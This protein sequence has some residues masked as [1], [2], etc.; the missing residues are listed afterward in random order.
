MW[1]SILLILGMFILFLNLS[2]AV[3]LTL[4]GT[5]LNMSGYYVYDNVVLIN[6]GN[7][8]IQPW[9]GTFGGNL[10]IVADNFTIYAGSYIF[11]NGSGWRGGIYSV[12]TSEG[13][14]NGSSGNNDGGGAGYGGKG[15]N[16]SFFGAEPGGKTYNASNIV[17]EK[18][19]GGGSSSAQ[20]GGNGGGYLRLNISRN[21]TLYGEINLNGESKFRINAV[22][23][24]GSGGG[25][26]ITTSQIFGNGIINIS[27]GSVNNSGGGG[28]GGRLYIQ[29]AYN[30]SFIKTDARA[31]FYVTGAGY[32]YADNG[33]ILWNSTNQPAVITNILLNNSNFS[34]S[35]VNFTYNIT[36]DSKLAPINSSI[37]LDG[38]RNLTFISPALNSYLNFSVQNISEGTHS[39]Y[40]QVY[41][42]SGFQ[43]NSSTYNVT[44]DTTPPTIT[45][46]SPADY[47]T[48]DHNN[49]IMF[50][51]S[52]SDSGVGL[53]S[54]W[55]SNTSGF[56]NYSLTC[57]NNIT[58]T[59]AGDGN[60]NLT[61]WA[62]DTLGN[63]NF[64]VLHYIISSLSP[65]INLAS[66]TNNYWFNRTTDLQFNFTV[67]DA[68][69]IDTCR[70]YGNWTPTG[71]D[72]NQTLRGVSNLGV[73]TNFSKINLL[74][75]N[76]KW[77]VWC[78]ESNNNAGWNSINYTFG[79][80]TIVP[81]VNIVSI[82]TTSGSQTITIDYS[83]SDLNLAYCNYT[84]SNATGVD[85][86]NN[87]ISIFGCSTPFSATTSAYG[88]F[89]LTIYANDYAG[90]YG[91]FR[92][93][94]T[95]T[96][97]APILTVTGGGGGTP[98]TIP[99]ICLSNINGTRDYQGIELCAIYAGINNYCSEKIRNTPLAVSDF[100]SQ[101][102]LDNDDFTKIVAN[103]LSLQIDTNTQDIA[104]FYQ[105][106]KKSNL[107][108]GSATQSEI[109]EYSLFQSVLGLTTLLS[110]SPPSQDKLTFIYV[111]EGGYKLKST[112]IS[113]KALKD[114]T[115]P[116]S[117]PNVECIIS[118]R[119][120]TVTYS[121]NDTNFFSKI[122]ST[123]VSVQTDAPLDEI[124]TKPISIVWRTYNLA[125]V[126]IYAYVIAIAG[127]GFGAF[128]LY[129]G[130]N[131]RKYSF[132]KLFR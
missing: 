106:Y 28:G 125:K 118:N 16:G 63:I 87:N 50:N 54:C 104:L 78:N 43:S 98:S 47:Y 15:S 102:S 56:A 12:R 30:N 1:K 83:A 40:A 113:N 68:H 8:T 44:V 59:E 121:I 122:L 19:S 80:D 92:K 100:S 132:E 37:I 79:V 35:T 99:V 26:W 34:T 107:F 129:R 7:I 21:L 57:G 52:V 85:G 88:D 32:D 13:Y 108:Q 76:Y 120:I 14:G 55:Y 71:W 105:G 110:I 74:D 20:D 131:K 31:G 58:I 124:E 67:N 41:D 5:T 17:T 22:A 2:S 81:I 75:N 60:Y 96:A 109:T 115:I 77:N 10:S 114:C 11:G 61:V 116:D 6:G 38:V 51:V 82:A 18:G 103:L 94:F 36:D 97:S 130:Y 128:F 9:N 4:D 72:I 45:F 69:T 46:I 90:N 39:W 65:A 93:Q 49:S 27:G 48:F 62:N 126:P 95:T 112:F 25:V 119:T 33:T 101:C 23:G 29:Y 86:I 111:S 66:P 64:S 117:N 84:I 70:L 73:I 89:N 123:S 3:D 53:N 24:A 42:S 91:Y 127:L